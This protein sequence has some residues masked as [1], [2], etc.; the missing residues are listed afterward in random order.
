MAPFLTPR[1]CQ[2]ERRVRFQC[3]AHC[4]SP[5]IRAG[6]GP[7]RGDAG[8]VGGRMRVMPTPSL[9]GCGGILAR[10]GH[11][12]GDFTPDAVLGG[13][14]MVTMNQLECP[15]DPTPQPLPRPRPLC[16]PYPFCYPIPHRLLNSAPFK[17][18]SFH[19]GVHS[20]WSRPSD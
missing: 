17:A 13:G 5:Q 1:F 10:G 19:W 6:L 14:M 4:S 9:P 8:V 11:G 7:H 2:T 16:S 3:A 18:L 15:E 20:T 12:R